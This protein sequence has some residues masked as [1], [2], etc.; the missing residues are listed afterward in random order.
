LAYSIFHICPSTAWAAATTGLYRCPSLDTE[1]FIHCSTSDQVVEVANRLFRGQHG[2]VLLVIDP[3][4]VAAN[5]RYEDAGN[6]EL[7]P[8]IYGP[9]NVNPVVGVEPLEPT[10]GGTFELPA[11]VAQSQPRMG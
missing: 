4:S 9:L 7:Y 6:G 3:E 5:I 8:H 10:D 11:R 1:G 2:L